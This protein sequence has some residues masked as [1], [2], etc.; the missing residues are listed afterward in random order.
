MNKERCQVVDNARL[1]AQARGFD[2]RLVNCPMLTGNA[3]NGLTCLFS[4]NQERSNGKVISFYKKL[5]EHERV[6]R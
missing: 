1:K 3:C 5:E 6:K 2:P 4:D